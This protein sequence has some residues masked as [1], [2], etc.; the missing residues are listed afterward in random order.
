MKTQIFHKLK[1]D[2]KGHDSRTF[3]YEKIL[4]EIFMN[5]NIMKTQ[6]LT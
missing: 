4:M 1:Y 5:A 2:L 3:V 6:L